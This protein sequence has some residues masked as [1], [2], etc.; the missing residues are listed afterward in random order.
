MRSVRAIMR[1]VIYA[2]VSTRAQED[3]GASLSTQLAACRRYAEERA[4]PVAAEDELLETHSG[5]ELWERPMLTR[6]RDLMRQRAVTDVICYSVDRLSRSQIHL[7]LLLSE[8]DHAGV[9]MHFV[10]EPL[11]QTAVGIFLQQARAFAAELER[12]KIRERSMRG[13]HARLTS[14]KIFNYGTDLYGYRRDKE[15]GVRVIH[16]GEAAVVRNL[17]R[18]F[19]VEGIGVK[20][21][22]RRLNAADV[23]PPGAGKF[24]YREERRRFWGTGQIVRMLR[25]P[26]YK[27]ETYALRYTAD[28]HKAG[29]PQY[30]PPDEWLR[31][32]DDVTP[33][34]VDAALWEMVQRRLDT[35]AGEKARNER[36]PVLLRGH[37]RC[38]VCGRRMSPERDRRGNI[39]FRCTSRLTPQGACG[40]S[41]VPNHLLEP[42]VWRRI[43]AAFTDSR[44]VT[45]AVATRK[46]KP[47]NDS[48]RKR[49]A[50]TRDVTRI[51]GQQ[52]R[53]L[54]RF[55]A[56][57][58][59]AF[60]WEMVERQVSDL[61]RERARLMAEI[62]AMDETPEAPPPVRAL[63]EW[64]TLAAANLAALDF[65]GRRLIVDALGVEVRAAG[66]SWT[67]SDAFGLL[68]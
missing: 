16:E 4:L 11:E 28:H 54:E 15:R 44:F 8:A 30:R 66:H 22:V 41:V 37:V 6:L 5:A 23:P 3:E 51:E 45:G 65:D 47:R 25:N 46:R 18:W 9:T 64:V 52:R 36:H 34:I 59:A 1:A 42:D 39:T 33:P 31:L 40:A 32:P 14:G 21:A 27:G 57:D 58:D 56:S 55:G 13:K 19:A 68:G 24:A 49:D 35:N 17:Y 12:E 43:T 50:L 26:A 62:A 20:E 2:R 61:Q 7:G 29:R 63:P 48:A 10:T 60:P 38:A 67:V 53:L